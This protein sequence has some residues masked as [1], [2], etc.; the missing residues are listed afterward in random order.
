MA[1]R[2]V[3]E[4]TRPSGPKGA[5][6]LEPAEATQDFTFQ[7]HGSGWDVV[8]LAVQIDRVAVRP[9]RIL[10]GS[11]E[12]GGFR[13]APQGEFIVEMTT[14]GL[15][16]GRRP[17]RVMP[18]CGPASASASATLQVTLRPGRTA[19]TPGEPEDER[20]RR[21]V[22]QDAGG[23]PLLRRSDWFRRR[24]GHRGYIPEGIRVVQVDSVR[25]LRAKRDRDARRF[26]EVPGQPQPGVCNWTPVGPGPV[27]VNSTTAWS[28]RVISIAFD[29]NNADTI[30]VGA[31]NGGV[32]R[33]TDRGRRWSPKSDYQNSL[34]IGALAVDPNNSQRIFA[35]TGQYGEA[36]GTFYGNGILYSANGG[37][38]WTELATSTFQRDEISRILF[39]P[40][41]PT[42][43]RMFLSSRQGV[44]QS[45]DG[46]M[47]W[48]VLRPGAS[49]DLV[50]I[51]G[52]TAVQLIA[53]FHASGIFTATRTGTS[54][55]AWTQYSS[56]NFPTAFQRIALGQC[57][58]T[59]DCI[60]AAFSDV[61]NQG[62]AGIA[63]TTDGGTVWNRVTPPLLVDVTVTS[64]VGG[65][66]AHTHDVTLSGAAMT[67]GTLTYTTAG[68]STGPAHTHTLTLTATQLADLR[69]GIGTITITSSSAAGHTHTFVLNRRFSAQTWYNFHIS[70]HPTSPDVVYYGEV[71]LWKTST[72]NGPWTQLPI[73]HTDNHAFAFAPDDASEIWSVGDGGVFMSPD[74]GTTFQHRNRDLQ[75]LEYISAAQHPQWETIMIGGTQDNGTQRFTGSPAWQ[76]VDGGDGG[77]TA[78]NPSNPSRMYHEYVSN[79]FYRS[80]SN[81][82]SGT[83]IYKAAGITGGAE[84]YA[85]FTLDPSTA[86]VC[87]FGGDELWRSDNNADSWTAITN[88][89]AGNLTAIAVHPTDPN[90]VYVGTT[91]G[92]VYQ[93][94]RTGATWAL[95][96]VTTT[97]I[98]GPNLPVGVFIS[99]L[100]VDPAGNLWISLASV[101]WS[102]T[103]GEFSND[104]IY[105]RPAGGGTWVSRSGGLAQANPVNSIVIDPLDGN[106]LYCGCD[107]GVFRTDNAGMSW[108][109]WDQGL[110]NVAVFDLQIHG[111]RRLLRAATHG[112][113]IW[114]RPMDAMACPLVD[115]YMRDNILDSGRVQP[116]PEAVHPF[117]PSL[118]AGHWQSEDIKV[119]A[120][121]PAF[122]TATP[123]D[124]YVDFASLQHRTARRN[125]TNRF[126]VQVHNR[127]VN[128]AHNVQVRAFFA[129]TSPGLPPLPADFWTGGRPFSGTPSGPDWTPVGAT[130]NLGDLEPGEPGLAEWDWFIPNSAPQHSCLL[131]LATCTE[132]PITGV[133][134]LN[135]DQLVLNSKHVTLKNLDVENAVAGTAMP[136][137]QS[138]TLDLHASFPE[139]TRGDF[140][141][142]WGT[143]PRKSRFFLV[144]STGP[145]NEPVV[146]AS[147]ETWKRLGIEVSSKHG[148]LFPEVV[149]DSCGRPERLDRK[150]VLIVNPRDRDSTTIPGIRLRYGAPV[151]VGM[152]LITPRDAKGTYQFDVV[153]LA[154]QRIVGGVTY[155]IQIV[156][157]YEGELASRGR[158]EPRKRAGV[159]RRRSAKSSARTRR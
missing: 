36:V 77:F 9:Q 90:T 63:R 143:L 81:G 35:G 28:G 50:L 66:P 137:S 155:R 158:A 120:P 128:V 138:M 135:P 89:I 30:Y 49:S 107:L 70:P 10:L 131:A 147:P 110:P 55:S 94:Q 60:Y 93:V 8:P 41:D 27:I 33:S 64:V 119:D 74:A 5:I 53:G 112:R 154:G 103:T 4:H 108:T 122:Q 1:P 152:N 130:V 80:D 6:E 85:P 151:R 46:G 29:Q 125:R 20:R 148:H 48:S 149:H 116:T 102:E 82:A 24:F 100:A 109:P 115:L 44:F 37:D 140:R 2:Q 39:D 69:D 150:R 21:H 146:D 59:P 159:A 7:V 22:K 54:W 83:W 51:A 123:V 11:P 91:G 38:T 156:S 62:I 3:K 71:R 114:E 58:N 87:Y 18:Q 68:P 23:G 101:L 126:Y 84:F 72:G 78:V 121:E 97:E 43:Q 96:D 32:W 57:R 25:A 47:N 104:H 129:P 111:P 153:R 117:D 45:I 15:H 92:R 95:A 133:G 12:T 86:N 61:N 40:T 75:L 142:Q 132:D 34:A 65:S 17:V 67:A 26:P 141:I 124:N 56:P 19:A 98:T 99:D 118:W 14:R 52:A 134:T 157:A 79:I 144:F 106:R 113:S 16:P 42:S 76:L 105:R 127:G 139:D 73:L 145:D 31:A 88:T 13:P 136:P